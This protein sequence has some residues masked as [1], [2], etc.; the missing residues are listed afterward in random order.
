MFDRFRIVLNYFLPKKWLT[1]LAGK[2][3]NYKGGWLTKKIID[4]FVRFYAINIR[5]ADNYNT[6]S[7]D[8]F[9]DFFIRR[10]KK[11][12]R[13]INSNNC[14]L[15]MPA[16]GS[17]SQLGHIKGDQIFQAKGLYYNLAG[18]LAGNNA[19][20]SHFL[21]GIFIN[22]YLSPQDY[23]RVHMPCRGVLSEM[24]YIPGRL[25]SVNPIST[26]NIPNLFCCNERVICVFH[27][28]YGLMVQILIGATI[29]GS[30]E[31]V[32]AGTVTSPHKDIAKHWHYPTADHKDAIIL[33][34]GDEMGC[35]KLGSTVINLFTPNTIKLIKN[36]KPEDKIYFGQPLAVALSQHIN[37]LHVS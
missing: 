27:T 36:L 35:F 1:R 26:R 18:L 31:T 3:A 33:L 21:N 15:V 30:I 37:I 16:D 11:D 6:A 12:A 22:I 8:T 28:D 29:I 24:I 2:A 10:L 19:L 13:R 34:K 7:Y 25:Y 4:I 20:A 5:E 32:W 23:H 17:I 9:N 14:F